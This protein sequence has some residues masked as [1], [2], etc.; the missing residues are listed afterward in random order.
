MK[1]NLLKETFWLESVFTILNGYEIR[2]VLG[3]RNRE[4][5]AI[6]Y[7]D[8]LQKAI[9]QLDTYNFES[10]WDEMEKNLN[11]IKKMHKKYINKKEEEKNYTTA[12]YKKMLFTPDNVQLIEALKGRRGHCWDILQS[13]YSSYLIALDYTPI[14]WREKE[15]GDQ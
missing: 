4:S 2:D 3:Q 13:I 10:H 5:D 1:E 14:G 15:K 11:Y 12:D 7:D 8:K 9:E 6:K